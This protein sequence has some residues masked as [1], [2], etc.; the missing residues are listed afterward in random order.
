MTDHSHA[1]MTEEPDEEEIHAESVGLF[2]LVVLILSFILLVVTPFVTGTQPAG[3]A[4]FLSPRNLPFASIGLML[5]GSGLIVAQFFRTRWATNDSSLF[6]SRAFSGFEG[7]GAALKYSLLFC[8]YVFVLGYV[9]FAFSTWLFGQI[10]LWMS[11]LRG[12]RWAGWNL[13]FAVATVLILRVM[14][15]LWFP[16]API[17]EYA[18]AWFAN[19]VGPYL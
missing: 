3:K 19:S 11:G 2:G 16:Q 6:W 13:A 15:G 10:C 7:M 8:A 18:P 9:G 12:W 4:W 1:T 17:L 14:M 5:I